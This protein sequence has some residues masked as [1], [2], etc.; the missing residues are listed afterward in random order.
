MIESPS[1]K[2][3]EMTKDELEGKLKEEYLK[4]VEKEWKWLNTPWKSIKKHFYHRTQMTSI[5]K[6]EDVKTRLMDTLGALPVFY[7]LNIHRDPE[8]FPGEYNN[9]ES[10]LMILDQMVRGFSEVENGHIPQSSFGDIQRHYWNQ[11]PMENS[12][13]INKMLPMMFSSVGARMAASRLKNPKEFLSVTV[14]VDGHDTRVNCAIPRD[15][16]KHR[17]NL[18]LGQHPG[19]S[20]K[21]KKKG[22]RTQVADDVMGYAIQ[23]SKSLGC[24]EIVDGQ[25]SHPE[26]FNLFS[27]L[28]PKRDAIFFDGGYVLFFKQYIDYLAGH[29]AKD[30][31]LCQFQGPIRKDNGVD[32]IPSELEAI[33]AAGSFRS[34]KETSFAEFVK[35]FQYF[36]KAKGNVVR[37]IDKFNSQFCECYLLLNIKKF[38]DNNNI[39]ATSEHLYWMTKGAEFPWDE[40]SENKDITQ[41]MSIAN[42]KE[43]A[44]RVFQDDFSFD[45]QEKTVQIRKRKDIITE[46]VVDGDLIDEQS[47]EGQLVTV[48]QQKK[49]QKMIATS[50]SY[51]SRVKGNLSKQFESCEMV[52]CDLCNTLKKKGDIQM[53]DGQLKLC[54]SCI[55]VMKQ[56]K[57]DAASVENGVCGW[58]EKQFPIAKLFPDSDVGNSC[59]N[60]MESEYSEAD[61]AKVRRVKSISHNK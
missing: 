6:I 12:E 25:Q 28:V 47:I 20:F 1:K 32:L 34:Q 11:S 26:T 37:V 40:V 13:K 17:N 49:K 18:G 45:E 61:L 42:A 29:G 39:S 14:H 3:S 59:K 5:E 9:L 48:Q 38:V 24:K 33:K 44:M 43:T 27:V 52:S 21:F 46:S 41:K 8:E 4:I 30:W 50:A 56:A 31:E 36:S 16:A 60:C 23:I 15:V 22:V 57:E 53:V 10:K 54:E 19:Y 35:K 7:F 51:S 55:G 58:C 2:L